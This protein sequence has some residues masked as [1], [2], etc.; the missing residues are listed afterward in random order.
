L[1][2]VPGIQEQGVFLLLTETGKLGFGGLGEATMKISGQQEA[3]SLFSRRGVCQ[4]IRIF[5]WANL[6]KAP[7]GVN[8]DKTKRALRFL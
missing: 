1:D 4:R 7:L 8:Y 5:H 3:T 6:A 2:G